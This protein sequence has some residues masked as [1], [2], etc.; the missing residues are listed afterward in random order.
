MDD[1]EKKWLKG[2]LRGIKGAIQ[3]MADKGEKDRKGL[4]GKLDEIF[5]EI[6]QLF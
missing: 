5:D 3:Q 1:D 6:R 2:K 4:D